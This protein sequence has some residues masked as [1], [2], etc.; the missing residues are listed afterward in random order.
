MKNLRRMVIL[1]LSAALLPVSCA[2]EKPED[3]TTDGVSG[4]NAEFTQPSAEAETVP[5]TEEQFVTDG[6]P[7]LDFGG[8]TVTMA[9]QGTGDDKGNNN[10]DMTVEEMTGDVVRDSIYQR[11]LAM[12]E[13]FN[14]TI[15][16]PLMTDYTTISN[17]IKS[18]VTAGDSTY[19]FVVNQLAQTSADVLNGFSMNLNDIPY[20]D[21]NMRWYPANVMESASVNGK[22]FLIVSDM[23]LSYVGQTWSMCFNKDLTTDLGIENLYDAAR[24]GEWTI[25]KLKTITADIYLDANGDGERDQEDTYGFTMG[26]NGINGCM[27]AAFLYGAGQQYLDVNDD[28]SFVHLLDSEH[29]QAVAEKFYELNNQ[30]GSCVYNADGRTL[31]AMMTRAAVFAPSQL[32]HY[33]VFARDFEGTFGVLP[34]PKFDASQE[35]YAT[36]CDAGCNC[37]SVPITCRDPE[38]TGAMIEAMSAYSTNYVNPAYVEIALQTKVA[39][40]EESVEMMQIVLDS[41][42][43]DFGYLYC[44]WNGWTWQLS[45]LF[46]DPGT[47]SSNLQKN[48][49]MMTK[50]YEKIIKMFAD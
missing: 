6:V 37:I 2:S 50:T 18:M 8:A 22:L 20:L 9:G 27:G 44:G 7:E 38:L 3:G 32:G 30:T 42:V 11:T 16:E 5:E 14:V 28:F 13:R 33:Y 29:A 31:T 47:Y 19:D 23:C 24:E 49:K 15:A 17:T 39:R 34:M 26:A 48:L 4:Q 10:L 43:M 41:R 45:N 12:E 46:K 35:R 36:L 40:D 1:L 25:D 21:F